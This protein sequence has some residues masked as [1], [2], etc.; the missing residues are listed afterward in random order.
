MK[1]KPGQSG[2]IQGRPAGSGRKIINAV[3]ELQRLGFNPIEKLVELYN[4][5]EQG[6][7][8]AGGG[9]NSKGRK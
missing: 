6:K 5:N 9:S 3:E 8:N 4:T 7:V 1:Y 2:N